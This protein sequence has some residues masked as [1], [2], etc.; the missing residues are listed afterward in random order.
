[1]AEKRE[2]TTEPKEEKT[3]SNLKIESVQ[4]RERARII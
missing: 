3:T 1:M 2:E 4:S